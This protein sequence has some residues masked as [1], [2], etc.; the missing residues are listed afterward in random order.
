LSR[1]IEARHKKREA[2]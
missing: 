2:G 1:D